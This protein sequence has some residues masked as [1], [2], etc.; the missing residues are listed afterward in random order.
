VAVAV[1]TS[2]LF[3]G[4]ELNDENRTQEH[5]FPRWLQTRHGLTNQTIVLANDTDLKYSQLLVPA[6]AACNGVHASQLEGRVADGSASEQD[7]W[8]WMLKIQL[9]TFYWES[10][11]PLSRDA[12]QTEHGHPIFPL[13]AVDLSYFQK[14]FSALKSPAATFEP[15]PS[16][17]LLAFDDPVGGFDYAD[18]LFSHPRARDDIYSAGMIAFDG[19]VWIALFD[20]GRRVMDSFIDTATMERQVRHG[21]DPR[22]FLPELMYTRSR[23]QWHPKVMVG[24]DQDGHTSHVMA[25]PTMGVP[26]IFEW[27]DAELATFYSPGGES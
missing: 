15:S 3:C 13:D 4:T 7:M 22:E 6:C 24:T 2:C 14:L 20:D 5:V 12:R 9:G 8:L 26:H 21:R 10:G 23:I 27:S 17:T 18:R 11:R 16:G 25:L 1:P 19:R